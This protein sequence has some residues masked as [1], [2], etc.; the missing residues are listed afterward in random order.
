MITASRYAQRKRI[1][2]HLQVMTVKKRQKKPLPADH[3][4]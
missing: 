3:Y 4:L 2:K 1:A